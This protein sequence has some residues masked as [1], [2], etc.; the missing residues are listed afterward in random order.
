MRLVIAPPLLAAVLLAAC[1]SSSPSIQGLSAGRFVTL[2]CADGKSFQLRAADDGK[3]V[4]VRS[5]AGSAELERQADGSFTGDGFSFKPS[6]EGGM[7]LDH[8]GKSQGKACK[9]AG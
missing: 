5:H 2:S 7:S 6:A 9:S 1:A 3:T 8:A 4:R